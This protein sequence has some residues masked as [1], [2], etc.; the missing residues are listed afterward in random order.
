MI[1]SLTW[2]FLGNL[3]FNISVATNL[4]CALVF[5]PAYLLPCSFGLCCS[6]FSHSPISMLWLLSYAVSFPLSGQRNRNKKI[7]RTEKYYQKY[8]SQVIPLNYFLWKCWL[9]ILS[10]LCRVVT[11]HE[12]LL[13]WKGTK[14]YWAAKTPLWTLWTCC[15]VLKAYILIIAFFFFLYLRVFF[16]TAWTGQK[17]SFGSYM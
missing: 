12:C 10:S 6:L 1:F 4:Q 17:H 7:L 5:C 3:S 11:S 14:D 13:H 16:I 15:F 9:C 2:N 8:V